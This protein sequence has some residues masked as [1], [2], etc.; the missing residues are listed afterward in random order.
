MT[1]VRRAMSDPGRDE[2]LQIE[3]VV[4]LDRNESDVLPIDSL[5]QSPRHQDSRSCWTSQM[6]SR[7]DWD[8]LDIV[9]A[10]ATRAKEVSPRTC[11]H[12]IKEICML[13]VKVMSCFCVNFFR[14]ST[15]PAALQG[16]KVKGGLA[17]SI[18]TERI[19]MS[20]VL[21]E[22]ANTI[23]TTLSKIQAA[24]HLINGI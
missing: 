24:D 8:Q 17:K 15:F 11:L 10:L 4:C 1:D 5:Q 3:L 19:C 20:I 21:L 2:G 23:P 6:A 22:P 14:N 12:P 18:P 16:Y 9:A 13:A 7:T